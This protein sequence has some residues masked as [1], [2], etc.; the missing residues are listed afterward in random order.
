MTQ[1]PKFDVVS[2][3]RYFAAQCFNQAW[4][5]MESQER[6]PEEERF[7][8]ALNQASIFHWL[9]REDCNDEALSIGYWQASRIQTL[10][11]N[12][13]EA[14]R[15]AH[16]CLSYSKH[17][18]PFYLGC[19][20]EALARAYR[21]AGD[22]VTASGHLSEAKRLVVLIEDEEEREQLLTDLKT[23]ERVA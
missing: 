18:S 16:I 14:L 3:H 20:H 2:A 8:V 5:L 15:H 9:Q 4:Q 10:L 19:A 12:A 6:S 22:S 23:G 7:M 11:N 21:F 1:P 13:T 17:L